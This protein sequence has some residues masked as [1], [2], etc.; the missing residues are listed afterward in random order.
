MLNN[1]VRVKVNRE[2]GF[3]M[4]DFCISTLKHIDNYVIYYSCVTVSILY[5]SH[6]Y[7]SGFF[8][9]DYGKTSVSVYIKL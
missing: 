9:F 6:H 8:E 2:I 3:D 4:I 7:K 5:F 1:E